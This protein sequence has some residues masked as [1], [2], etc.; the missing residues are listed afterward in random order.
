MRHRL[1]RHRLAILFV[2]AMAVAGSALWPVGA[3]T[4]AKRPISYDVMDYWRAIQAPKLSNDG[5]WLAYSLTSQ[6]DDGELVVRN[7]KTNQEFRHPRGTGATFTPDGK[8]LVFTIVPPRAEEEAAT[9]AETPA[10]PAPAAP[11]PI[12]GAVTPGPGTAGGGGRTRRRG[13]QRRSQQPRHHDVVRRQGDDGRSRRVVQAARRIVDVARVLPRQRERP[14][15]TRRGPRRG[16]W[17][18]R[19]RR[20]AARRR[21]LR[22]QRR[23][24]RANPPPRR[25]RSARAR[26]L[27]PRRRDGSGRRRL[28]TSRSLPATI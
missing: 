5:Q 23:L 15:R 1:H 16:R 7:L 6:G 14:R 8:F 11:A 18:R 21:P 10:P 2:A 24:R 28:P 27:R 13:R 4:P 3:Q 19:A 9:A 20:A 25:R 22:L 17:R 12:G 26:R